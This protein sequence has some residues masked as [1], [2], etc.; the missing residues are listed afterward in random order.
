MYPSEFWWFSRDSMFEGVEGLGG[1]KWSLVPFAAE[2]GRSSPTCHGLWKTRAEGRWGGRAMQWAV[3][4]SRE[5]AMP[6]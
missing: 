5:L 3:P 1:T 6:G 2:G 4:C